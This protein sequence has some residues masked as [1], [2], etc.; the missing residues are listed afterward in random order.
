MWKLKKKNIHIAVWLVRHCLKESHQTKVIMGC[1]YCLYY[2]QYLVTENSLFKS[3]IKKCIRCRRGKRSASQYKAIEKTLSES[4]WPKL[5]QEIHPAQTVIDV[6]AL[7]VHVENIPLANPMSRWQIFMSHYLSVNVFV[8]GGSIF[9]IFCSPV[10]N[11]MLVLWCRCEKVG[12]GFSSFTISLTSNVI[13]QF[14]FSIF[15]FV[16]VYVIS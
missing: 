3:G 6:S 8:F 15:N 7:Q 14:Y 11:H 5:G 2:L 12:H 10:V 9:K 13:K 4:D 1:V 16:R